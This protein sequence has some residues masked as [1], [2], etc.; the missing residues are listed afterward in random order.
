MEISEYDD[1]KLKRS[2]NK[3]LLFF[4]FFW[5]PISPAHDDSIELNPK[6]IQ[7]P[8]PKTCVNQRIITSLIPAKGYSLTLFYSFCHLGY[9]CSS[10]I[11]VIYK[12]KS[13]FN[14]KTYYLFD[15]KK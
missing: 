8:T 5:T 4:F 14:T 13:F 1:R 2:Y 10:I 12:D 6:N 15:L 9:S 7:H 3:H 11:N